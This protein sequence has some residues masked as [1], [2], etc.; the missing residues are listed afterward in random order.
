MSY[1]L[2]P[3]SNQ[4]AIA[5][6]CSPSPPNGTMDPAVREEIYAVDR[7]LQLRSINNEPEGTGVAYGWGTR[8]TG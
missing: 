8:R 7:A 1:H 5:K 6:L 2:P 3:P 4:A